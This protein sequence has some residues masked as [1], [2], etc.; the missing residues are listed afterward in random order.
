MLL[1]TTDDRDPLTAALAAARRSGHAD[2]ARWQ[3]DL[4]TLT[5]ELSTK[6][7][8]TRSVE[9]IRSGLAMAVKLLGMGLLEQTKGVSDVEAWL[10]AIE[11]LGLKGI[12]STAVERIKIVAILPESPVLEGGEETAPRALLLLATSCDDAKEA[13]LWLDRH[14]ATRREYLGAIRLAKWLLTQT[15]SGRVKASQLRHD[16]TGADMLLAD[17]VIDEIMANICG[18]PRP[19]DDLGITEPCKLAPA[20]HRQA[21]AAYETLVARLDASLARGLEFNGRSWFERFVLLKKAPASAV[22][23]PSP[24]PDHNSVVS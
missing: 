11:R 2:L 16:D 3:E 12:T 14:A 21:R 19:K 23:D 20:R 9:M 22:L 18:L 10:R 24:E 13:W 5:V 6:F 7:F 1:A 17:E 8:G 15:P 4:T